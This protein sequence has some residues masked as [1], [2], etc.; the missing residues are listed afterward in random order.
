M[1]VISAM[2]AAAAG[3]VGA[4]ASPWLLGAALAFYGNDILVARDRFVV[5]DWRHRLVGLPLYYGS[6]AAFALIAST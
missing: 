2:V 5:R 1:L 6:M 4:G 3:A